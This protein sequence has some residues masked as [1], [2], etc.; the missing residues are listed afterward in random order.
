MDLKVT[1][2]AKSALSHKS[3][4]CGNLINP[5]ILNPI[6]NDKIRHFTNNS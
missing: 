4:E 6:Q 1:K 3:G 2:I 5:W